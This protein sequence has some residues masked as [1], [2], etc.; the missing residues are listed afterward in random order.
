MILLFPTLILYILGYLVKVKKMT[1]LI[2]GYN[3][4]STNQQEK[5]NVDE[6][7]KQVGNFVYSL[8]CIMFILSLSLMLFPDYD[9]TIMTGGT[10]FLA[11]YSILGIIFLNLNKSIY[12]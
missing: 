3:T 1:F 4:S 12:K 10:I 9:S 7:T 5:Y 2:S 6:L 8:S 11:I